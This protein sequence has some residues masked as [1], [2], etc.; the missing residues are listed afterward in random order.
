MRVGSCR[1]AKAHVPIS[2]RKKISVA[3]ENHAQQ[4]IVVAVSRFHAVRQRRWLIEHDRAIGMV[5][6][7]SDAMVRQNRLE[8]GIAAYSSQ[9][10]ELEMGGTNSK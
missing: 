6:H 7:R 5:Y 8:L 1:V 9:F 4:E 3:G 2:G 10:I